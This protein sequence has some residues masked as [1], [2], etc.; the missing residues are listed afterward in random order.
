VTF[1]KKPYN[2]VIN[3]EELPVHFGPT[4]IGPYPAPTLEVYCS[5]I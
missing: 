1:D 3:G 2:C 5:R 4:P